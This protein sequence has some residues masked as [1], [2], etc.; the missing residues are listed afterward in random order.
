VHNSLF[1]T[2]TN[3]NFDEGS[4]EKQ[5]MKMIA[6]RDNL[7]KSISSGNLH[8]A[9]VFTV[10]SKESIASKG[11]MASKEAMIKKA[12]SIAYWQPQMSMCVLFA[13]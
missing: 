11:S 1:I 3:A 4:I 13:R 2:I 12:E 8:E 6:I 7:K 9:A 5:I 10:D